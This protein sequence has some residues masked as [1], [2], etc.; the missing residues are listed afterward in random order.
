MIWVSEKPA[1]RSMNFIKQYLQISHWIRQYLA[2]SMTAVFYKQQCN[3]GP[4]S[5]MVPTRLAALSHL[6]PRQT[7]VN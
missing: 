4:H 2:Y 7:Y 5:R 6:A 3:V 1:G